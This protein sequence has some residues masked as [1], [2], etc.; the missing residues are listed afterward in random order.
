MSREALKCPIPENINP[1]YPS[2]FIF[3]I[4][5]IPDTTFFVQEANLPDLTLGSASMS[6][7]LS[8]IPIPGDKLEFGTLNI[9]FMV[10]ENYTNYQKL[11]EWILALGYPVSHSQFTEFI[12]KQENNLTEHLKTVS[13]ATLG[14]LDSSMQP[15][16]TYT[17]IDCYP[18]KV[19]GFQFSTEITNPTP[20]K[21]TATFAFNYYKLMV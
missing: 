18:I 4:H 19:G 17:F 20:L 3:S 13:D 9:G 21:A 11:T 7:P 1:L 10:D 12:N 16:A 6:T 8:D 5:K 15:I 14:I 2:N